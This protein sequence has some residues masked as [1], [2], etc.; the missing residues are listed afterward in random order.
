MIESLLRRNHK[1]LTDDQ[2]KPLAVIWNQHHCI[3]PLDAKQFDK[4]WQDAIKF[5]AN[6]IQISATQARYPELRDNIYYQINET[7]EKY[8]IAYKQK[9]QLI[10]ATGKSSTRKVDGIEM[11]EYF[12]VHNKTYLACIPDKIVRHK[13]PITYLD[14]SPKFTFSFVDATGERYTFSHKTLSEI[15]SGLRDLGYVLSDGADTALGA[16]VQAYKESKEIEDN[17]D[18]EYIGFFTD[19]DN[20]IIASNIE[21][22]EP[23]ISDARQCPFVYRGI[24]A[25]FWN[26]VRPLIHIS[27]LGVGCPYCIHVKDK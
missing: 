6:Q 10:E 20:K 15:L 11:I 7:P 18:M 3:P 9:N 5:I 24:K 12:L 25:I 1:I 21:I 4:Q 16:M 8:V 26:Q 22:K 14:V 27:S 23:V 13:N 19:K 17:D 2:I